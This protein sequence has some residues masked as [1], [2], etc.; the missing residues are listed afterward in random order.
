MIH[1]VKARGRFRR[2]FASSASRTCKS[3]PSLLRA[4][5]AR[6]RRRCRRSGDAEKIL[7]GGEAL[8]RSLIAVS[9]ARAFA[10]EICNMYGPTETTIWSD[11]AIASPDERGAI[12]IGKPIANTQ[13]YVLDAHWQPVPIGVPGELYIGGDGVARGYLEPA[14]ADGRALRDRSVP[15]R[16]GGSTAPA[17][18]RAVCRT[19]ISSSWAAPITR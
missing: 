5:A 14:R 3:T 16:A 7:F 10:G 12:P 8:P 17:I 19:A 13:V 1:G 4:H 15:R 2:K 18:W 11:R 9:C 6:C